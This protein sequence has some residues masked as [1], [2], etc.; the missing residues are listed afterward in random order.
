MQL[1]ENLQ[2]RLIELALRL[3]DQQSAKII[4]EPLGQ[5]SGYWF[6]GGNI[7]LTPSGEILISGRFRNEGDA[8][9]GTGAGDRGLE[10]AVY[11]GNSPNDKFQKV[12][13]FSKNDIS[14]ADEVVSIEGVSLIRNP[15]NECGYE[16]F[17][18]TEKKKAY[19]K[20]LI[21]FQKPG[22]GVWS[23]DLLKAENGIESFNLK[24]IETIA[25][26]EH[27]STLHYKDPVVF[28]SENTDTH[29]IFCH[30]PFSWS[31]SNSGLLTRTNNSKNFHLISEN[32]L[33][34]GNSWDVA[35]ARV[36]EKLSIPKIGH[37]ADVPDLSLYFYDGAE[38]LRPLDQNPEAAKRPRGYSCEEIG[39][40]A[41]GWDEEFPK[42]RKLSV[43]FP[44]FIS[45]HGTGCSRYVS[46]TFIED[47]SVFAT[48]QQSQENLSQHL[49]GNHLPK[50]E[51]NR[52]LAS[53]K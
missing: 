29:V 13:S 36:T 10:C 37:F 49:A 28:N 6:G 20:T 34:R 41:W 19:P 30:H 53:K 15:K 8:R 14:H 3:I 24:Q 7:C 26:S 4:I 23:I 35:C 32:I 31:S 48:W 33:S 40:L 46:A 27:G 42:L 17:I 12:L 21:N 51:V 9:T 45:P 47:G 11:S 16:F 43:D 18:S 25:R 39:G 50:N 1:A 5:S 22:T 38:C 52:I 2:N 44:F